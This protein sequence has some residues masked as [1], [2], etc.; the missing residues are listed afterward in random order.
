MSVQL[1]RVLSTRN[2]C[3]YYSAWEVDLVVTD[4]LEENDE[5]AQISDNH[6]SITYRS[7]VDKSISVS[8]ENDAAKA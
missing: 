6:W 3:R 4:T 5:T 7:A 1:T 8:T 2:L